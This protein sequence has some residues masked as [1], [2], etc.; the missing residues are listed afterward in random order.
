VQNRKLSEADMTI[1]ALI[2]GL[3]NFAIFAVPIPLMA[4]LDRPKTKRSSQR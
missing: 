1:A 3:I 4:W 2:N